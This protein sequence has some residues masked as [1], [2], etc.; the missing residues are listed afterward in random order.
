MA[1]VLYKLN[2]A[3]YSRDLPPYSLEQLRPRH[4]AFAIW[5]FLPSQAAITNDDDF[6]L[7]YFDLNQHYF[8]CKYY[9]SD[10]QI[11]PSRPQNSLSFLH[12]NVRPLNKHFFLLKEV[13]EIFPNPPEIICI[14]ETWLKVDLI[15]NLLIPDYTF[16]HSPAIVTNA[17]GVAINISNK[18][19]FETTQEY[20]TEMPIAKIF[21]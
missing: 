15:K 16:Y 9:Y 5:Y 21:G 10:H 17:G 2:L 7:S 20:N 11:F 13:L 18:F 4:S 14:S 12:L 1:H 3:E 8:S 19:H 6:H